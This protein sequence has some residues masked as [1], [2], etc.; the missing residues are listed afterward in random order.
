[1][2]NMFWY[3]QLNKPLLTPPDWVFAPVWSILYFMMFLSLFFL[4]KSGNLS[5]KLIPISLFGIQLL[6]NLS[7]NPIFFEYHKIKLA[8]II[9]ILLWVFILL[10]II[11]FYPHSKIA[12]MLLIPYFIWSF[13]AS[14]LTYSILKLN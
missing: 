12:S 1:M 8:F 13:F 9:S 2:K 14:Y 7:W 5:Q 6:L 3:K 10:C 11:S 4:L